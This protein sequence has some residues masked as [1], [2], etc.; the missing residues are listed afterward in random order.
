[1]SSLKWSVLYPREWRRE[2]GDEFDAMTEAAP[3]SVADRLDIVLHALAARWAHAAWTW[4]WLAAVLGC[5]FLNIA[6]REVQYAAGALLV[7]GVAL[8]WLRPRR[9]PVSCGCLYAAILT[10]SAWGQAEGWLRVAPLYQ[11]AVSL[12]PT[13]LGAGLALLARS[14]A[15]Y[16]AEV[17]P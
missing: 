14:A 15:A 13:L 4:P 16:A 6:A 2:F 17:R 8:A 5:G 3:L 9:W 10:S 11:T 7:G 1:M 12:V